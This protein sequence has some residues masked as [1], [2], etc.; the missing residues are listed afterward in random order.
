MPAAPTAPDPRRRLPRWA[1]I[2][3]WVTLPPMMLLAA[4]VVLGLWPGLEFDFY[5]HS[6]STPMGI[7]ISRHSDSDGSTFGVGVGVLC[8]VW[9]RHS[10]STTPFHLLSPTRQRDFG[11]LH[12]KGDR[13]CVA[14]VYSRP[15]PIECDLGAGRRSTPAPP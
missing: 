10:S 7:G 5:S 9:E 3:L 13:N 2:F 1:R 4:F 6:E 15:P 14:L 12:L 11:Q 8:F